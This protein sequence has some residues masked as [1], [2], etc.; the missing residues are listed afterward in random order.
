MLPVANAKPSKNSYKNGLLSTYFRRILKPRQMDL[1]YASWLMLQLCIA[2][3][4]AFGDSFWHSVLTILS[5]VVV[6][7]IFFGVII[8][9]ACWLIANKFM[10][11]KIHQHHVEQHVEWLYAFDVHCNSYFP[12]F[13]IL[14]VF[15]FLVCPVLLWDTFLSTALAN[16]VYAVALSYY[17]YMNFLGYS[18]LPFLERT[19]AFL[20]P[21]GLVFMS[22]PFAILFGFNPARF[23]LGIYFG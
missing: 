5:A 2:P 1:E 21:I 15:Q 6:D 7:Y 9:T 23:T 12:L 22:I 14:Y 10:R 11:K 20:W 13:L 4:T 17:H 8:A 18:A 19:E 3:K 16:V